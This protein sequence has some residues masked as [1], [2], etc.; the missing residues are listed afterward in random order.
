MEWDMLQ[1]L[2]ESDNLHAIAIQLVAS[3]QGA[4]PRNLNRAIH[5]QV[6]TWLSDVNP[7][8][9]NQVHNSQEVPLSISGLIG[10]RR[11]KNVVKAGDEFILRAGILYG[12]LISP[13]L[14]G[15]DKQ[16]LEPVVMVDFPFSVKAIYAMPG[17]HPQVGSSQYSLL[18]KAPSLGQSITLEFLS[19][20]SFKQ[21]QHIQ[22]FPLPHSVFGSLLK[23]WNTFAPQDL[24]LPKIQWDGWVAAYDLK[25]KAVRM[26]GGPQIG[27]VGWVK[28]HFPNPE[29]A[30]IATIL[31]HFAYFSGVG[32]KTAMGMGQTC[33]R[34]SA[35]PI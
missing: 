30:R 16:G 22:P 13:L 11:Q 32:R 14:Q 17:S 10:H 20:T 27:S 15:L 23:R 9:G 5:A 26:E 1:Q 2:S 6:M 8:L 21:E 25:T 18:A 4:L 28:Y 34:Q 29:Q 24:A 35:K 33:L 31:T 7:E 3:K 19:P 12:G